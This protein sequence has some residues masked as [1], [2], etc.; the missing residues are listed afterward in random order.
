MSKI[1][2]A[3]LLI[4][5]LIFKIILIACFITYV[6]FGH[7][8]SSEITLYFPKGTSITE[9]AENLESAGVIKSYYTFLFATKMMHLKGRS[10]IAGEYSF[11]HWDTTY[12]VLEK[13]IKG[14]RVIHKISIPEGLTVKQIAEIINGTTGLE[15]DITSQIKDCDLM[16]DTYFYFYGDSKDSI[17]SKMKAHYDKFFSKYDV[18]R[19]YITSLAAIVEKETALESERPK[20]A[21]VYVNRLAKGMLLQADPTVIYAVTDG[22]GSMNRPISLADLKHKSPYNTYVSTGLPPSP[23]ACP[24]RA[25][26]L[27][28]LNPEKHDLLYFVA[29]GTGGH[30]FSSNVKDHNKN[31]SNW[32]KLKKMSSANAK[33]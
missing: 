28:A 16:P 29:D 19:E 15:G 32:R 3:L 6:L 24:G 26:L 10:V 9:I 22:Y 5:A 12:S 33:K 18:N 25:S 20:V 14:D 31:V 13:L 8:N 21:G 7:Y 2:K 17:I 30:I 11:T 23:I 27:A 4:Y 1:S